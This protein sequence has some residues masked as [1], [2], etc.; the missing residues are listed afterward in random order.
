MLKGEDGGRREKGRREGTYE[1]VASFSKHS[2]ATGKD[3]VGNGEKIAG[4]QYVWFS[5]YKPQSLHPIY[6]SY[7]SYFF[8]CLRLSPV[9]L[10]FFSVFFCFFFYSFYLPIF[11]LPYLPFNHFPSSSLLLLPKKCPSFF[12]L[13]FFSFFFF[14]FDPSPPPF[15]LCFL[16]SPLSLLCSLIPPLSLSSPSCPFEECS[17]DDVLTVDE[18]CSRL[19]VDKSICDFDVRTCDRS[20]YDVRTCDR[21]DSIVTIV[22]K[23]GNG[24][25]SLLVLLLLLLLQLLLLL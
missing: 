12:I 22:G 17:F 1:E 3:D 14:L 11:S 20:D 10:I 13:F 2:R 6:F 19:E 18:E 23:C 9:F 25:F 4:T 24:F 15:L 21:S 16:I 8:I 5:F 7:F